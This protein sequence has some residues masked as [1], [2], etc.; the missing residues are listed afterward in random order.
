[1][2]RDQF[3]RF[4]N[5]VGDFLEWVPKEHEG[6]LMTMLRGAYHPYRSPTGQMTVEL[7]KLYNFLGPAKTDY[8]HKLALQVHVPLDDTMTK[9]DANRLWEHLV[10]LWRS[11]GDEGIPL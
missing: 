8:L 11:W 9:R 5:R 7:N 2:D 4:I 10:Y 1:M 6:E 3:L